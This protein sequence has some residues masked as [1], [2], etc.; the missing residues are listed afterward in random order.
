MDTETVPANRSA[1]FG[2]EP[3]NFRIGSEGWPERRTPN[4]V[5]VKIGL[6]GKVF[7]ILDGSRAGEQLFT[8]EAALE[9]TVKAGKL[10]PTRK[11]WNEIVRR[12]R[13]TFDPDG[14]W[15]DD[16]S[17]RSALALPLAGYREPTSGA[18]YYLDTRCFLWCSSRDASARYFGRRI[19]ATADQIH[20]V[21]R[22]L[23]DAGY[24]VRCLAGRPFGK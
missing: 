8:L 2:L 17:V 23:K 24:S 4:G 22:C 10:I 3:E 7:E 6:G 11:Q 15:Q 19:S 20:P 12:I 1:E 16:A 21:D 5:L 13:G 9:E 18:L 14:S